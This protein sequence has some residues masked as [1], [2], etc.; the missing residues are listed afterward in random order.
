MSRKNRKRREPAATAVDA[1]PAP[2]AA[3]DWKWAAALAAL[4]FLVYLRTFKHSFIYG[5]DEILILR[6]VFLERWEHLWALLTSQTREGS[7]VA[8]NLYRPTQMFLYFLCVQ[9]F[10]KVPQPIVFLNLAAHAGASVLLFAAVRRWAGLA[11]PAA[12]ALAALWSMHP[13][14]VEAVAN[15]NGSADPYHLFPMLGAALL[16]AR[17]RVALAAGCYLVALGA[18]EAA[19]VFPGL[20]LAWDLLV[21]EERFDWKRHA[22]LWAVSA[23]YLAVRAQAVSVAKSVN[24]YET[25]NV[26]T[27][28]FIYRLWT[29][30][31]VQ[32][33]GLALLL[34]PH[35]L[36][37]EN[38]VAVFTSPAYPQVWI[39]LLVLSAFAAAAWRLRKA[40]PLFAFGAAWYVISYAPMSNLAA[41]INALFW[42]HWFYGPSIGL[43]L[44]AAALLRGR[45]PKA[46]T[47][48][49][50]AAGA[51]AAVC[52][53][54]SFGQIAVWRDSAT[55]FG[56]IL[57]Y[58]KESAKTWN[59]YAM[60]LADRERIEEAVK[61]YRRAIE[62]SDTYPQTR[63]NLGNLLRDLGQARAK[64]GKL[65]E[66]NTLLNAAAVNYR[67]AIELDPKFYFS[68]LSLAELLLQ[69]GRRKEAIAQL[70]AA[71]AAYPHLTQV[72]A[73]L[74]RL[75]GGAGR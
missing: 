72:R 35:D 16:F 47:R 17:G 18:K 68:R 21:R 20:A 45:G 28:H 27:E 59:N 73:A 65:D 37:P 44:A 9:A 26:F 23:G 32:G 70:E 51:L 41:K 61:A 42:E 2:G 5:D 60:G 66:A 58:E 74:D 12:A 25:S 67:R 69:A 15:I 57:R 33:K 11:A 14:H 75:K 53:V 38:T 48:A 10:G 7:G 49:A 40:R 34:R 71:L 52:A 30:F 13:M 22:P 55:L 50:W 31:A 1:A 36:H 3:A 54:Y 46:Q 19:I 29:F 43:I 56:H 64:A 4:V 62:L 39:P 8:S 63:H 24:F 6:N